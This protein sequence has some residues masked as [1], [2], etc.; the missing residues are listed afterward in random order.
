MN[1][2]TE[3]AL[4]VFVKA[5]RLRQVKTRLQPELTA[6]QS[7]Q[8]YRAIVE[9]IVTRMRSNNAWDIKIFFTP[10]EALAEITAWLG[11]LLDYFPQQG[12]NLGDKMHHAIAE[13]LHQG[14]EKVVLVGSD[15]PTL[16]VDTVLQAF[17]C[18]SECDVVIGPTDDGGY[19][20]IGMKSSH[21]RL[22]ENIYW[23]TDQ[24][25]QQSIQQARKLEL[26]IKQ[27]KVLFDIDTHHDV[28]KLW[29]MVQS[30]PVNSYSAIILEKTY[31]TLKQFIQ[32]EQ[33]IYKNERG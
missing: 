16:D 26:Q 17:S 20:L 13:C 24:V 7:L 11:D 8:L 30:L 19:Y 33:N 29:K 32:V 4:I 9:G 25:L 23:S 10:A 12:D 28:E 27:L 15:I 18:L 3:N 14:Y 22:F 6:E 21:T 5:P 2:R 31:T 1:K